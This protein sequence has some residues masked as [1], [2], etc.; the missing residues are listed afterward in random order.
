MNKDLFEKIA[1]ECAQ[2]NLSCTAEELAQISLENHFAAE[3]LR[4]LDTVMA[5]MAQKKHQALVD[6][7]LRTSRLLLQ[8]PKTFKNFDFS[9]LYGQDKERLKELQMLAPLYARRNVALIGPPGT[10]KTHLAQ[11]FG[12]ECCQRGINTYFLKMTELRE[13][14]DNA[15]HNGTTAN[16]LKSLVHPACLIID[17]VGHCHFD[18]EDTRLFF[19]MVDRRYAKE[20]DSTI[21]FTSN[22]MPSSWT[23]DFSDNDSLACAMDRAF[24]DALVI[25][26]SGSSYRGQRLERVALRTEKPTL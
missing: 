25:M 8:N 23:E 12:Y 14:M 16:L 7:R 9:R 18:K 24:D 19:D 2:L 4:A 3:S 10:G 22:K 20:S 21:I 6:I 15:R 11:A 1:E 13:K 26:I 17:E 5:H